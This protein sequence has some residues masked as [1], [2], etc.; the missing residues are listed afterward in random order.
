MKKIIILLFLL[1][2][3]SQNHTDQKLNFSNDIFLEYLTLE[4]FRIKLTEYVIYSP[5]P[6]I[7]N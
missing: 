6:N 1:S 5:F 7:D 4:E 3:C 2:G